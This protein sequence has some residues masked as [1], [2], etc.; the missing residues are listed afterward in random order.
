MAAAAALPQSRCHD[1][2]W[3]A[4][5]QLPGTGRRRLGRHLHTRRRGGG[6]GLRRTRPGNS[7]TIAVII[8]S[9][10][11]ADVAALIGQRYGLPRRETEVCELTARGLS[12][13]E[14][15]WRLHIS[16]NTGQ[17]H[18]K[19]IL[20]KTTGTRNRRELVSAQQQPRQFSAWCQPSRHAL[21]PRR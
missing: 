13:A 19:S 18:L 4:P 6:R 14:M 7:A 11:P 2:L 16:V 12:T 15:A 1:N 9:A 3:I 20:E 21:A 17:D 8:E 10:S 5:D